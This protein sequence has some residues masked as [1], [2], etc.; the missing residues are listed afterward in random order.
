MQA[1]RRKLKKHVRKLLLGQCLLVAVIAAIAHSMDVDQ[2][3]ISAFLGGVVFI[4]PQFLFTQF[5]FLFIENDNIDLNKAAMLIGYICKFSL[6]MVLFLVLVQLPNL[7]H[8]GFFITLK[9]V[10]FSQ[11]FNL[12]RPLPPHS[13]ASSAIKSEDLSV[14]YK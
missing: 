2:L 5:S 10:I 9:L 14:I 12:L 7:H 1:H 6:A 4:A 3:A 13:V 8:A 11:I